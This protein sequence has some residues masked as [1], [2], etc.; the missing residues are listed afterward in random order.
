[1]QCKRN[2]QETAG[3]D[4]STKL[5]SLSLSLCVCVCLSS[6]FL[7]LLLIPVPQPSPRHSYQLPIHT[8]IY[9]RTR[10]DF[11]PLGASTFYI[12]IRSCPTTWQRWQEQQQ[13]QQQIT[14]SRSTSVSSSSYCKCIC[15]S[16][17]LRLLSMQVFQIFIYNLMHRSGGR[18]GMRKEKKRKGICVALCG[19]WRERERS[20]SKE[21]Q[22]LNLASLPFPIFYLKLSGTQGSDGR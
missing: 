3:R 16:F 12:S 7:F 4:E 22:Q 10:L 9:V 2:R 8:T 18:L 6:C 15:H 5:F 17:A 11:P 19:W 1:M 21:I 20:A 14:L 13:Q